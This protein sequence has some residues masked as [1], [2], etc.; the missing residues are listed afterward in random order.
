[1]RHT[2]EETRS[3]YNIWLEIPKGRDHLGYL[4][5]DGRIIL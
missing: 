5:I 1:M 2:W 4:N 3:E